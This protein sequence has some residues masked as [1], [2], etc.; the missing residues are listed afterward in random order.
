MCVD[1]INDLGNYNE[2]KPQK[3]FGTNKKKATENTYNGVLAIL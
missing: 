2:E 1:L 3:R